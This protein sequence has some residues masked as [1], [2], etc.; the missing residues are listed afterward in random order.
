MSRKIPVETDEPESTTIPDVLFEDKGVEPVLK[1]KE[2]YNVIQ[3]E[4][5]INDYY[6][7]NPFTLVNGI[8]HELEV[9]FG[10][11]GMKPF[12]KNDYDAVIKHLKSC[13]FTSSNESGYTTLKITTDFLDSKTGTFKLSNIRTEIEGYANIQEYCK[14]NDIQNVK[15]L[16]FTKKTRGKKNNVFINP[17]INNDFNFRVSYQVEEN[18]TVAD[19]PGKLIINNWAKTKKTYR[20]LHRVSFKHPSYPIMV[21]ISMVKRQ[22][23]DRK[24]YT[25]MVESGIMN[26]AEYI[27]IELEII[28]SEIGPFTPF[29]SAALVLDRLKHVIHLIL[30][31]LQ[32]TSYPC[33]YPEQTNVLRNYLYLIHGN[34]EKEIKRVYPKY[35][36]GPS[37]YTLQLK[38]IRPIR[39]GI[40]IPNITTD[41]TVTDKADG[42]RN[43][44]YIDITGKIYL[45]NTNMSVIFTGAISE[46][47]NLYNSL[48]DGELITH[49]KLGDFINLYASFDIYYFAGE[50]VRAFP[51]MPTTNAEI[52]KTLKG[53]TR[54]AMLKHFIK[55]LAPVSIKKNTN[56]NINKSTHQLSPIR[57]ENKIFYPHNPETDNIFDACANILSREKQQLFEYTTDGLIFT[58]A[59]FGVASNKIGQAGPKIKTTWDHSFKWKPPEYNTIDFLVTTEKS[60]NGED[61]VTPLYEG[62][63]NIMLSQQI[64]EYKT[65]VLRCSFVESKHGYINPCQDVIDDNIPSRDTYEEKQTYVAKPARFYPSNPPDPSAGIC[66][67]MLN[68]DENSNKQMM[69][70]ENDV[71]VD[72]TIV[73]FSYDF[74][75]EPGWR[76]VPLRVRYDKTAE[77]RQGQTQYG[78][79]YHVADTNWHSIHYPITYDMITT[80]LNIPAEETDDGVYYNSNG[81]ETKTK[82]LRDFHN[83]YVKSLLIKSVSKKGNILIDYACGKGGDFNKWINAKLSFVFG[84]DISKDN[85]ENRI[86]GAC[87]RFLNYRKEHK[88]MPYAL[89][90]NGNSALNI[91]N[92]S[93]LLND[94]AKQIT[95]AV[96]GKGEK[97]SDKSLGVGVERQYGKGKDGFDVSSCQFAMHY[98]FENINT[99]TGFLGNLAE[100]TKLNGYFIGTCYDGKKI[101]TLLKDKQVSENVQIIHE[102][103]KIWEIIKEYPND[104]LNDDVSSVGLRID[105]YQESINKVFS[106]YLVNFNYFKRMIENYGFVLID[107]NEANTLGFPSGSGLFNELFLFMMD[108]CNKNAFKKNE[109]RDALNMTPYE[110]KISFLNRYF[111]FKKV[112]NVVIESIHIDKPNED[113]PKKAVST[114]P[115]PKVVKLRQK[116]KVVPSEEALEGTKEQEE[117]TA[118]EPS[119]M[120]KTKKVRVKK[121]AA[122][123]EP[124]A[125]P[126]PVVEPQ[127]EPIQQEEEPKQK[128]VKKV[129]NKEPKPPKEPKTK[130]NAI[131]KEPKTRK[132]K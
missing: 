55:Y 46:N 111:I 123:V 11:K 19:M 105:V 102:G 39:E 6:L 13:G 32:G 40:T 88:N 82:G 89:F 74:T 117:P 36:I 103:K 25:S 83:L 109:Y 122:P 31:G 77:L 75:K 17:V 18:F 127:Q 27:E 126:E 81:S 7:T 67:I 113:V 44:L 90:V 35:F 120:S 28:N 61:T 79:A 115:I 2:P 96:F 129:N 125:E 106:E 52:N 53:R 94:K 86:N 58:H 85:L 108:E 131:P 4:E 119:K 56:V 14:T 16:K 38:N 100:C 107:T 93:A 97:A 80:G 118:K 92:G 78:N 50:D 121:A 34:E 29:N 70:L 71:F 10:N 110:Q 30:S 69:T 116:M 45:I 12:T 33:S 20:Y 72:N 59:F 24:L 91:R 76:W 99:L 112:R 130:R 66:K 8:N 5:I 60:T 95:N 132:N 68:F 49:N 1:K 47:K 54:F 124:V 37:S 41:Y 98:F 104:T 42:S 101:F 21:D 51:F 3:F 26:S 15:M 84:V 87:A 48:L 73:E 65:I 9:R 57:I 62:G 43:L 23:D 128:P 22:Q 114:E 63:T 64:R